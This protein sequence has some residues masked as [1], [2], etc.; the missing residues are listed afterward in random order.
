MSSPVMSILSNSR[1]SGTAAR[2]SS[3]MTYGSAT[4]DRAQGF[5]PSDE[6]ALFGGRLRVVSKL[7]AMRDVHAASALRAQ[8]QR[9]QNESGWTVFEQLED[10]EPSAPATAHVDAISTKDGSGPYPWR[11]PV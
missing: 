8:Q 4:A 6:S 2:L 5:V 10:V 1:P 9:F 3:A 11:Q 7:C